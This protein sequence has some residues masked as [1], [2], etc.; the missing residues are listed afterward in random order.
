VRVARTG[1]V[2]VNTALV[3]VRA[4]V[5]AGAQGRFVVAAVRAAR[6]S[7]AHSLDVRAAV[8]VLAALAQV[9]LAGAA[10]DVAAAAV[11]CAR[12]VNMSGDAVAAA[13]G[14]AAEQ[15]EQQH[16]SAQT[17]LESHHTAHACA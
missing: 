3:L 12:G 17:R 11:G 5:R 16:D 15:Q 2:I 6:G 9:A 4:G 8:V 1:L 7:G 13:G 10:L 14:R